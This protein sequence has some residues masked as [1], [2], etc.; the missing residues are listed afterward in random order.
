MS[1]APVAATAAVPEKRT[2]KGKA[3][4]GINNRLQVKINSFGQNGEGDGGGL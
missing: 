3:N 1:S 2:K 4:E